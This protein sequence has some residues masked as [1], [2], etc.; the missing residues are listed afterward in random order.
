MTAPQHDIAVHPKTAMPKSP[1]KGLQLSHVLST[2]PSAIHDQQSF[3]FET[4]EIFAKAEK[5]RLGLLNSPSDE[6]PQVLRTHKPSQASASGEVEPSGGNKMDFRLPAPRSMRE[7][8]LSQSNPRL[9]RHG[10]GKVALFE[11]LAGVSPASLSTGIA[12]PRPCTDASDLCLSTHLLSGSF[13]V[14]FSGSQLSSGL[15]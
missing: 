10:G 8:K 15:S 5:K 2:Q 1:L 11:G 13:M 9:R 12:P 6:C 14:L 3:D 7:H 4:M